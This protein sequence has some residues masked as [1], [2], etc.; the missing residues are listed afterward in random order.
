[1]QLPAITPIAVTVELDATDCLVLADALATWMYRD[2]CPDRSLINA[3]RV[4]LEACA[5]LAA[6]DTL[7]DNRV[8][9]GEML[10]DTRRV[11]GPLAGQTMGQQR[12]TTRP[13]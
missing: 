6:N 12:M 11:W 8:P 7:R 10:D 4:A 5:A 3:L 1:M 2:A 13:R 9:E